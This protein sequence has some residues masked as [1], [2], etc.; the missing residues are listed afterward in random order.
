MTNAY[1]GGYDYVYVVGGDGN[2]IYR[3]LNGWVT[4]EVQAAIEDGLEALI[5]T[6][7]PAPVV[8]TTRILAPSPN[9]FNPRTSI[10]VDVPSGEDLVSLVIYDSRGRTVR[11]LLDDVRVEAGRT[12]FTWDGADDRGEALPSGVYHFRLNSRTGSTVQKG[13]L[14]R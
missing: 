7:A 10:T 11:R 9:P 6:D 4:G 2:V 13:V 12:A 3:N 8:D 14:V 1:A 5:A